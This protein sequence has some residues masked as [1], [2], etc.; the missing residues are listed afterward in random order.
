MAKKHKRILKQGDKVRGKN[1]KMVR[2]QK[3]LKRSKEIIEDLSKRSPGWIEGNQL[4]QIRSK[5]GRDKMF[6]TPQIM[7]EAACDY[8]KW[9][10]DNPMY[11]VKPQ[12]VS[13]GDGMGSEVQMTKIPHKQ[14]YTLMALCRFLGCASNYFRLFKS[15]LTP[16]MHDFATVIA[17]IEEVIYTQK[18]N[19]AA[20]GFYN[21]NIIARD[22][23]LVDRVDQTSG[24]MPILAPVINVLKGNSPKLANSEK[25]IE[26]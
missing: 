26:P 11:E 18:F 19:G 16:D 20:V 24:D 17:T 7:W 15:R 12:V 1:G 22:L 14:P 2:P 10:D 23:G 3:S 8:F 4:W 5:H 21:A 13:I 25:Q 6:S 9:A